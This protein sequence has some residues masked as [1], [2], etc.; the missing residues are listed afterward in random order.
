M[1]VKNDNPFAKSLCKNSNFELEMKRYNILETNYI[2][3]NPLQNPFAKF[4]T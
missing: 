3:K 1:D 4:N 2:N